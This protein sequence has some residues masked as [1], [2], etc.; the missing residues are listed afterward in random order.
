MELTPLLYLFNVIIGLVLC[1]KY[2]RIYRYISK[3]WDLTDSSNR[4]A[5]RLAWMTSLMFGSSLSL[6]FISALIRYYFFSLDQYREITAVFV[7]VGIFPFF[8]A[9]FEEE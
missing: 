8:L 4:L 9:H 6:A 7:F 3:R 5:A 1:I 2:L